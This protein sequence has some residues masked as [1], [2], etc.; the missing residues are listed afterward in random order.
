MY[1][2]QT[3]VNVDMCFSASAG[4]WCESR[5]C[6]LLRYTH[7]APVSPGRSRQVV[8]RSQFNTRHSSTPP[9]A[10]PLRLAAHV[11]CNHNTRSS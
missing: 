9:S 4:N 11:N 8:W 5:S 1:G 10:L 3:T 7:S 2:I 6:C